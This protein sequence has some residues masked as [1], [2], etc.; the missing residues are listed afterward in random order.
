MGG[1]RLRSTPPFLGSDAAPTP[2]SAA[3]FD[4]TATNAAQVPGQT[5]NGFTWEA[6]SV[7]GDHVQVTTVSGAKLMQLENG[8]GY[9]G[10]DVPLV[11]GGR[12][13]TLTGVIH[14]RAGADPR[15]LDG[16]LLL[17]DALDS[18]AQFDLNMDPTGNG[19]LTLM[20]GSDSAM[21]TI[22]LANGSFT[23]FTFVTSQS[24]VTLTVGS[25]TLGCAPP[26]D[27]GPITKGCKFDLAAPG[28]SRLLPGSLVLSG[29]V[30]P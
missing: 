14:Q 19:T 25:V 26:G 20:S 1:C 22:A 4:N 6:A 12:A 27:Y 8:W 29:T 3:I 7:N 5:F 17:T 18:L 24:T 15:V 30:M 10:V 21:A 23:P 16:Y 9:Q 28:D 11:N 2:F 13:G